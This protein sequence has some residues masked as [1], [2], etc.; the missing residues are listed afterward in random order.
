M[1]FAALAA[2]LAL[3]GCAGAPAHRQDV[4]AL[5]DDEVVTRADVDRA[6]KDVPGATPEPRRSTLRQIVER[7]LALRAIERAG[8]V[9]SD[10]ELDQDLREEMERVGGEKEHARWPRLRG[11]TA[12]ENRAS[13]R[14]ALGL[15]ELFPSGVENARA[16]LLKGVRLE[17][18][19]LFED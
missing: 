15:R 9:V 16:E 1:R 3:C 11:I 19:D 7:K 4:A 10:R 14:D 6:L 2:A 5:I 17:P 8:I 18:A 13:R 12:A